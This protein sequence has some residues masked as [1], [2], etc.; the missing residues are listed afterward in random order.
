MRCETAAR[1]KAWKRRHESVPLQVAPRVG[2]RLRKTYDALM[3]CKGAP[4]E[5]QYR[6]LGPD[7]S[8]LVNF[9]G[10]DVRLVKQGSKRTDRLST[11]VLAGEWFGRVYVD[12]I[13]EHLASLEQQSA[14]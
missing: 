7:I 5:I 8:M 13:A 1:V 6:Y 9:Y 11:Y 3:A 10:L 12:Y 14:A 4:I 2:T